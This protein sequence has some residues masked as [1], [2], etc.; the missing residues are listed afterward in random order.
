MCKH[1]T[2]HLEM[3]FFVHLHLQNFSLTRTHTHTHTLSLTHT[4][5]IQQQNSFYQEER[6]LKI[7]KPRAIHCKHVRVSTDS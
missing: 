5:T 2:E 6:K 3:I 4:D 7:Q 1:P